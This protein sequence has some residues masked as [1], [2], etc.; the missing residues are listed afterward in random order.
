MYYKVNGWCDEH[1][2]EFMEIKNY[3]SMLVAQGIKPSSALVQ[4]ACNDRC[5]ELPFS[6]RDLYKYSKE[7]LY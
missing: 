6:Y 5:I 4:E 1:K 7:K 2:N 3:I